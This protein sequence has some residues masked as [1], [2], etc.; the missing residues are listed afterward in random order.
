MS[1]K[2]VIQ[3]PKDSPTIACAACGKPLPVFENLAALP[4][5][6]ERKCGFCGEEFMYRKSDIKGG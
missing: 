4:P 6:F 2:T 5:V 3:S 1:D